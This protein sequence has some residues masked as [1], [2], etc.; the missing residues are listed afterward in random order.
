[1]KTSKRSLIIGLVIAA[2]VFFSVVW[3]IDGNPLA[4]EERSAQKFG[5][6]VTLEL[7][8]SLDPAV[9]DR[10]SVPELKGKLTLLHFILEEQL[11]RAKRELTG[12]QGGTSETFTSES[13]FLWPEGRI[14]RVAYTAEHQYENGDVLISL[15]LVHKTFS[16]WM[17]EDFKIRWRAGVDKAQPKLTVK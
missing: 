13:G 2:L 10:N 5:D 8:D 7:L 16:D 15:E 4:S 12:H 14:V 17:I 3:A 9:I 6:K 11:E 1:M